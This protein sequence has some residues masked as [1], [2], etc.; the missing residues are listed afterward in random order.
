MEISKDRTGVS[1]I[2]IDAESIFKN[3]EGDVL[4]SLCGVEYSQPVIM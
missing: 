2:C 3:R 4:G 1:G